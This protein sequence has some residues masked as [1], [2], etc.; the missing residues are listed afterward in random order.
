MDFTPLRRAAATLL[1]ASLLGATVSVPGP[2]AASP[3]L[4]VTAEI[5]AILAAPKLVSAGYTGFTLDWEA[6]TGANRY[7]V[8]YSTRSDLL[9][10]PVVEKV[11]SRYLGDLEDATTYYIQY[12][13]LYR[14]PGS[15]YGEY[16]RSAWS[17]TLKATTQANYPGA[18]TTLKTTGGQDSITV[19]WNRTAD[20]THYTV[21]IADNMAMTLRPRTFSNVAGTSLKITGLTHG[22]R[23]SM[24]SFIRVYAHNKTYKTRTSARLTAYPAAPAVAGTEPLAVA[25]QNLLCASCTVTGAPHWNTRKLTHLKTI[26][27]K[28]PDVLLLQEAMNVNIPGTASTKAMTDFQARLKTIGYAL[29]RTPEKAG[30]KH[31]WNRVAYKSSKYSVVKRG[32]FALPTPAGQDRRGAAWVALK[33]KKTG[34]IFYA[35]SYHVDPKLPLTG[36]VSK[37][38]VMQTIDRQLKTINTRNRPVVVG[39]DMNSS[40]Y[41]LPS[42]APHEAFIKAGWT[43][44]ASSAVKTDFLYPTTNGFRKQQASTFGR[45]DYVFT[46]SIPGTVSYENVLDIDAAGRLLSTPGSDHNMVLAKLK[47]K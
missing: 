23:S 19:S 40:F 11:H 32:T 35:V 45:I 22:S 43:D 17:P 10:A 18:F 47:L 28:N 12:R 46:K 2:A 20:T 8:R 1:A 44:T 5:S 37:T 36:S 4:T 6:V 42:N 34:K 26:K 27:A 29:D 3:L 38:A 9:G 7:E 15:D 31:Y 24:P 13:A 16:V 30:T 25:S 14:E 39:G 41:Q 21:T 33:S